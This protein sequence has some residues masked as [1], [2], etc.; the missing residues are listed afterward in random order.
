M[1]LHHI[2]E[3]VDEVVERSAA[4]SQFHSESSSPDLNRD[5]GSLWNNDDND[6]NIL[7]EQHLLLPSTVFF[8][9]YYLRKKHLTFFKNLKIFQKQIN[10][11]SGL[12]DT[13][14]IAV[15]SSKTITVK[16]EHQSVQN[17]CESSFNNNSTENLNQIEDECNDNQDVV[18]EDISQENNYNKDVVKSNNL[19]DKKHYINDDDNF[20]NETVSSETALK[21]NEK[22]LEKEE[23]TSNKT[24]SIIENNKNSTTI[25]DDKEQV[26]D[27][28]LVK[29]KEK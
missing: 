13:R 5:Q 8:I 14:N 27:N 25:V 19:P 4:Y 17:Q 1:A 16:V 11:I 7:E 21:K 22:K 23:E 24:H 6:E 9:F 3:T 2:E 26:N 15:S 12:S 20:Q 29:I 28:K 18:Q 10:S